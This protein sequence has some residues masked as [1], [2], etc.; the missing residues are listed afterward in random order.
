MSP[1]QSNGQVIHRTGPTFF[2]ESRS[3]VY[4]PSTEAR[5]NDIV[6]G[7][8]G[9]DTWY[10]TSHNDPYELP[11]LPFLGRYRV[12]RYTPTRHPSVG[13]PGDWPRVYTRFSTW[14]L[15]PWVWVPKDLF[16]SPPVSL[17]V[18]TRTTHLSG[19]GKGRV[20]RTDFMSSSRIL[21]LLLPIESRAW[22]GVGRMKFVGP[23]TEFA[24]NLTLLY[25]KFTSNF[26][27]KIN[28][29]IIGFYLSFT[30]LKP[31]PVTEYR[32]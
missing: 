1:C 22:G 31:V 19:T 20:R 8:K 16:V 32:H 26:N 3:P 23:R 10:W 6:V 14:T 18:S 13:V 7:G 30:T 15:R 2:K 11:H 27:F 12:R 9:P 24:R 21:S 25:L 17:P 5:L 28:Q 29:K 4:L